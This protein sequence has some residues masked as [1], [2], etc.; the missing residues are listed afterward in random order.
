M[1]VVALF[2]T[3]GAA[4]AYRQYKGGLVLDIPPSLN[5]NRRILLEMLDCR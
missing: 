2:K 1:L 5:D 3:T 4:F